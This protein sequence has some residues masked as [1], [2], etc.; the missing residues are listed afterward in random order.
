MDSLIAF[1]HVSVIR[2]GATVLDDFSLEIPA[3]QHVAVVGPNGS[4]KSTVLKLFTQE[5]RPVAR[6]DTSV[7]ILGQDRWTQWDLRAAIG[8]VSNDLLATCTRR[9][10]G[11]ELL[12]SSFFGS[13]GLWPHHEPTE[14]M[15]AR[16]DEVL[17]WLGLPY[18]ARR[19]ITRMSSGE[20][21]RLLIGRAL[22]H[23][24]RALV[25]DEPM[26]SL[27]LGAAHEVRATM[28]ALAREGTTLFLVTHDL[29]DIVPEIGR[30]VLLKRGRVVGDGTP[31]ECLTTS[32][33]SDLYERPVEVT[34]RDGHYHA[35]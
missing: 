33:L 21:R 20:A 5:L 30:V 1:S 23:R 19:L 14:A 26:T 18:L 12:L 27:D 31:A 28:S 17:E 16:V 29:S 35:W 15:H 34:Y 2:D 22:I 11:R 9:I 25:L 4:G 7:T 24:P 10:T 3:G 8:I 32:T 13:I 6:P